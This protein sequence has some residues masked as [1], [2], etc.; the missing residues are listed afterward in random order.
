MLARE[1]RHHLLA[2]LGHLKVLGD[3]LIKPLLA[4]TEVEEHP[5][6]AGPTML[7]LTGQMPPKREL[8][9]SGKSAM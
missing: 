7:R 4:R 6:D 3:A 5:H 9:R 2:L 8:G 1:N